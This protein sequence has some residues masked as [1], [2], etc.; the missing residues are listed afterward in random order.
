MKI[1]MKLG[2]A[3]S[4]NKRQCYPGLGARLNLKTQTLEPP[5]LFHLSA[6]VGWLELGVSAEAEAELAKIS[7]RN[8]WF[9][10]V[11][12][13]RWILLAEARRWDA[14]LEIARAL[15]KLAPDRASAWLHQAY[16]L[17][18]ATGGGLQQAWDA[19]LPAFEKFP[20]ESTIPYNLSCYA[21][22]LNQIDDARTWLRRAFQN[23][24]R[25]R[26]KKMALGDDDLKSLWD[27]IR[28]S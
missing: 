7:E 21:C 25:E 23:G 27:E 17:R 19:L 4:A 24:D 26:L 3:R 1:F 20:R 12:E 11:L 10:D 9:P 22:Q 16:A 8:Q 28:E 2:I 14:A 13:V 15:V 18:R 6:A 5:D